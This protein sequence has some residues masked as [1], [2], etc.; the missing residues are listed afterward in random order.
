MFNPDPA[1]TAQATYRQRVAEASSITL[2]HSHAIQE[3]LPDDRGA[4]AAVRV[5]D[6]V[7]H[8]VSQIDVA[9]LFVYAG[10]VPNTAFLS[11]LLSLDPDGRIPVDLHMATPLPGL[12][13]A[14]D[15]RANAPGHA[16]ISASDGATA[17]ISAHRYLSKLD[18]SRAVPI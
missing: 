4:L 13:A 15:V 1:T 8:T 14:G 9:G 12:F 6:L 17:A 7:S 3:L 5:H 16:L 2:L 10:S 11:G 18:T